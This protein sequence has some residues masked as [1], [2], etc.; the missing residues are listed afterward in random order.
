M[1]WWII[2]FQIK[3]CVGNFHAPWTPLLYYYIGP[4]GWIWSSGRACHQFDASKLFG[5]FFLWEPVICWV[6]C[7][8][9]L[10]LSPNAGLLRFFWLCTF[11][12][13]FWIRVVCLPSFL[14]AASEDWINLEKKD[15][16]SNCSTKWLCCPWHIQKVLPSPPLQPLRDRAAGGSRSK[17]SD[18]PEGADAGA[19]RRMA[20]ARL[21]LQ[22]QVA[23][24]DGHGAAPCLASN[25][26]RSLGSRRE[27]SCS[28]RPCGWTARAADAGQLLAPH[29]EPGCSCS[30]PRRWWATRAHEASA[31]SACGADTRARRRRRSDERETENHDK[32]GHPQLASRAASIRTQGARVKLIYVWLQNYI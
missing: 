6:N 28:G 10:I 9:A 4:H 2:W 1:G 5:W 12:P 31:T 15:W 30:L 13:I 25:R 29:G 11:A 7:I 26:R 23:G 3:Y 19:E 20:A 21:T 27:A 16:E 17:N 8:T 24:G 32:C 14:N 18:R 22:S